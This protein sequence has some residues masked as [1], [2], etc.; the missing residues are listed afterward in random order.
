M[1]KEFVTLKKALPGFV[2]ECI[3]VV[4]RENPLLGDIHVDDNR[5]LNY[6]LKR[7]LVGRE[8]WEDKD[9]FL[10]NLVYIKINMIWSGE[11]EIGNCVRVNYRKKVQNPEGDRRICAD[12]VVNGVILYIYEMIDEDNFNL[13]RLT[14]GAWHEEYQS[15]DIYRGLKNDKELADLANRKVW[16]LWTEE[17]DD[18]EVEDVE[19]EEAGKEEA[20]KEEAGKEITSGESSPINKYFKKSV[21]PLPKDKIK[22]AVEY[23][24][25]TTSNL[26][27]LKLVFEDKEYTSCISNHKLFMQMLDAMGLKKYDEKKYKCMKG[28]YSALTKKDYEWSR[29]EKIKYDA[30]MKIFEK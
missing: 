19:K 14:S 8:I 24:G 16:R 13:F 7:F 18:K 11:Y 23:C 6:F 26:A 2:A 10:L 25:D 1:K 12:E 30:L 3:K 21:F 17:D 27:F 22:E 9:I 5:S 15:N 28:K 4:N 29:E 20:G